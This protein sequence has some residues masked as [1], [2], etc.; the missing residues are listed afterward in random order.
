MTKPPRLLLAFAALFSLAGCA[1]QDPKLPELKAEVGQLN[2]KLSR[3]TDLAT[4]LEQQTTLNRQS[5]NGVYLLP[6]AK[7]AALVKSEIGELSLALTRV[8]PDASGVQA[9]LE[10]KNNAGQPLPAFTATLNWGQLDPVTG[11]PLTVDMQTQTIT[12]EPDL[13]PGPVKTIEVKFD[14][15]TVETLGFVHLHNIVATQKPA[16]AAEP[17]PAK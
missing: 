11:K 12:V 7:S 6:A 16:Q 5:T 15:V 1:Q 17:V 3:L 10:I 8:A 2:Q 14:Q 9:V 4:A 13:L